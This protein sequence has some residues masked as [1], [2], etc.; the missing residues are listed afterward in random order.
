M[1]CKYFLPFFR[2]GNIFAISF[3]SF[4][5]YAKV[6]YFFGLM[7]SHILTLFFVAYNVDS[8][9]FYIPVCWVFSSWND[10]FCLKVFLHL[11]RWLYIFC[12]M[13]VVHYIYWFTSVELLLC[14]RDKFQLIMAYN[15]FYV[16]YNVHSG[17]YIYIC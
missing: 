1:T 14:P 13:Y 3:C 15:P 6:K 12:S 10:V 17:F 7:K 2:N 8:C 11:L 5:C 16:S 9:S 4:F